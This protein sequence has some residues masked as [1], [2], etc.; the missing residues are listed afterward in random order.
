ME[1][2]DERLKKE[3]GSAGRRSRDVE[4]LVVVDHRELSDSDR[5]QMFQQELFNDALPSL[6]DIP[7]YHVCWLSSTHPSDTLQRRERLGYT[8]IKPEEM[9]GMQHAT[10]K[11]GEHAGAIGINEM[12]AYKLPVN[13]YQAFMKEAHH[14]APQ[15]YALSIASQ[16]DALKEQAARDGGDLMEGD[17]MNDLRRAPSK[18]VFRD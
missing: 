17:G 18:G 12:L 3:V 8:L 1:D 16:V 13:L 9:P 11:T 10:L 6:P 14:D 4:D 5:I 7:G 15:R 2:M